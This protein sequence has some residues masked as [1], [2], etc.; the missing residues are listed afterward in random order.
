MTAPADKTTRTGPLTRARASMA[1]LETLDRLRETGQQ[2]TEADREVLRGW[3]GWGPMAPAF[4]P[5]RTGGWVEI[6][7]KIA[8]LL[9][10]EEQI[11]ARKA[12][13][14]AFYTPPEITQACWQILRDLGFEGG[15]ILEPG[16]GAGVF[17][18]HTPED[19]AGQV[20][21]LGIER[22]PSTAAIA[23]AIYPDAE[24]VTS[25]LEKARLPRASVDA[26]LGNVPF[27]D[28]LIFDPNAPEAVTR[29]LHN[30]AIWRS[31]QTLRPGGVAVLI[32]SR[33]TLDSQDRAAREA[34]YANCDL[35]SAIRLPNVA[36]RSGGTEPVA[37]IL[38]LRRRRAGEEPGDPT[39]LDAEMVPELGT[40]VNNLF[41]TRPDLVIGESKR[42]RAA[43]YG[44]VMRV[45]MP[46]G[47]DWHP[48]LTAVAERVSREALGRGLSW[49]VD[50][51]PEPIS[52]EN[53][54]LADAEGRK[55]GSFHLVDGKAV[56]VFEGTLRPVT[57]R[58][59]IKGTEDQYE[60][61]PLKGK[62][63]AELTALIGLRDTTVAVLDAEERA[64]AQE[65]IIRD[66]DDVT[67]D[68]RR[69]LAR[70]EAVLRSTMKARP[71]DDLQSLVFAAQHRTW[72]AGQSEHDTAAA[73]AQAW[74]RVERDLAATERE[75]QRAGTALA[76]ITTELGGLRGE[77]NRR[78]DAYQRAYGYLNRATISEGK[79]DE[80]TGLATIRR[81]PPRMGGFR[82]DPDYITVLALE[83]WDDDTRVGTKAAIFDR[84]VNTA[85]QRRERA[86]NVGEAIAL[87]L[88][89]HGKLH[90]PTIARLLDIEVTAV[91]EALGNLA[92]VDP[93]TGA[94]VTAE[95]YLSGN[96][97]VKLDQALAAAE[98]QPELWTRNVDALQDVQPADLGPGEIHAPLGAPWIPSDDVQA[99]L[100]ELLDTRRAM[101]VRRE[102]LT[103]TWEVKVDPRDK[104]TTAATAE[105]GTERVHAAKLV[106]LAL[107]GQ[108]PEVIDVEKLPD[109]TKQKTKNIEAT[110]AAEEKQRQIAAR[111]VE[112]I[113]EDPE[114]SDR[115]AERYN[116]LF[117]ATV[118]RRY[119]GSHLTFP[120]LAE[121][122]DPYPHQRDMV[123]RAIATETALCGHA[124]GGGKTTIMF[125]TAMKLRQLGLVQKPMIV[126]PK[127]L[128]EQTAREGKQ[129]F[130]N[131][132]ILVAD[133]NDM[134]DARSRKLFAAR[135]ATGDWDAVI[136]THPAFTRVPMHERNEAEYLAELAAKYR[137]SL[138]AV[139]AG[140]N[141]DE[142]DVAKV[143]LRTKQVEKLIDSL[144]SR[145]EYLLEHAHDDG[146]RFEHL[147][148]DHLL[149]DEFHY[150]KNLLV[151][152][153][154]EGFSMKHSKRATDM[155][156]KLTWLRSRYDRVATFYTGTAVSNSLLE[157]YIVLHYLMPERLEEM[158]IDSPDAWA[159]WCVQFETNV[160]IGPDGVTPRLNRRPSTFKNVRE[161]LMILAERSDIRS[162]EDL[163]LKVP[164]VEH[165]NVVSKASPLQRAYIQGLARRADAL[166][167]VRPEK[168]GDNMLAV[169]NDGRKVAVDPALVGLDDPGRGKIDDAI[170]NI[171]AT[172][173]QTVDLQFPA[174]D[175]HADDRETGVR[176][177]FQIV[178]CDL[179][180]PNK[181]RG[182][183]VYGKIRDGLVAQGVPRERIR[184]IH[185]AT[186]DAAKAKLFSE[187]RSGK[188][189]V[190]LGSTDKLG[191]GTNI[192]DRAVELHH[193]D[194]PWK[195]ADVEQ[196]EGRGRRPGN[197]MLALQRER[198]RR[199]AAGEPVP[200]NWPDKLKIKRYVT[201]GSFDGFMWQT[202]ER[203]A[204]FIAQV[205]SGKLTAGVREIDDVGEVT[206]SFAEVKALA[207]GNPLLMDM[208]KV[209]AEVSRL[210]SLS[211]SHTR[212]Q[213]RLENNIARDQR[214]IQ[215]NEAL[216]S[217]LEAIHTTADQAVRTARE[218][219]QALDGADVDGAVTTPWRTRDGRVLAED[220]DVDES[221]AALATQAVRTKQ[222]SGTW[223]TWRGLNIG[224]EVRDQGWRQQVLS[225]VI[226][227]RGKQHRVEVNAK[228]LAKGQ[229]YRFRQAVTGVVESAAARAED[230]R[231]SNDEA[232]SRI[233][234]ARAQL[235]RPFERAAEL[236][237]ARQR[238]D[239][240]NTEL[241]KA[242]EPR[243]AEVAE[244]PVAA[245][246]ADAGDDVDA[247]LAEVLGDEEIDPELSAMVL[248]DARAMA[249]LLGDDVEVLVNAQHL[250]QQRDGEPRVGLT[251]DRV[252]Y[253]DDPV[254]AEEELA[255]LR[256]RLIDLPDDY[257]ERA[258][259]HDA[260][261]RA[262]VLH[263]IAVTVDENPDRSIHRL[264]VSSQ[265]TSDQTASEVFGDLAREALEGRTGA[266][267]WRG[268][269][270]DFGMQDGRLT[271]ALSVAGDP[272]YPQ[273]GTF[274]DVPLEHDWADPDKPWRITRALDRFVDTAGQRARVARRQAVD[275]IEQHHAAAVVSE[276][277][278]DLGLDDLPDQQ[279]TSFVT[280]S[281][282]TS[283]TAPEAAEH[284]VN[285]LTDA[286]LEASDLTDRLLRMAEENP[287]DQ[288]LSD[289]GMAMLREAGVHLGVA[290]AADQAPGLDATRSGPP[291]SQVPADR[292]DRVL[293]EVARQALLDPRQA[294]HVLWRGLRLEFGVLAG[295]LVAAVSRAGDE[296]YRSPVYSEGANFL[297]VPLERQWTTTPSDHGRIRAA[298][299]DVVR[300]AP[301]RARTG[302]EQVA[303]LLAEHGG[304]RPAAAAGSPAPAEQEW[305]GQDLMALLGL[306]PQQAHWLKR[307]FVALAQHIEIRDAQ[308]TA[309]EAMPRFF[310]GALDLA[311]ARPNRAERSPGGA[312][313]DPA[314]L[315]VARRYAQD[316]PFADRLREVGLEQVRAMLDRDLAA[317]LPALVDALFTDLAL[318]HTDQDA[319]WIREWITAAAADP[320][321][322]QWARV[323][324]EDN[325]AQVLD[326]YL[327]EAV[328]VAMDGD[329]KPSQAVT[330]Y[331]LGTDEFLGQ[332]WR[333]LARAVVYDIAH[334][335]GVHTTAEP[336]H[337]AAPELAA[338]EVGA[339]LDPAPSAAAAEGTTRTFN[340]AA[341]DEYV[342]SQVGFDFRGAPRDLED[343]EPDANSDVTEQQSS[344]DRPVREERAAQVGY[345]GRALQLVA[346]PM[347]EQPVATAPWSTREAVARHLRSVGVPE[348]TV[349]ALEQS[350]NV[351]SSPSGALWAFRARSRSGGLPG[352]RW[353]VV[354]V[355]SGAQVR[356][357]LAA[358]TSNGTGSGRTDEV[359]P[360]ELDHAGYTAGYDLPD[361]AMPG[362]L[363]TLEHLLD[364]TGRQIDWTRP[365]EEVRQA[366]RQWRDLDPTGAL[367]EAGTTARTAGG[368]GL[369]AAA[370][371]HLAAGDPE[372]IPVTWDFHVAL[373]DLGPGT[374][375][376][377][378]GRWAEPAWTALEE[379][380]QDLDDETWRNADPARMEELRALDH[381]TL[382]V[383]RRAA[384]MTLGGQPQEA[385]ALLNERADQI[386]S[387][388]GSYHYGGRSGPLR[389]VAEQIAEL[390]S[391]EPTELQRLAQAQVGDVLAWVGGMET[392]G[393]DVTAWRVSEAARQITRRGE[394][395]IVVTADRIGGRDEQVVLHIP[396]ERSDVKDR[397][398]ELYYPDRAS[399]RDRR[400][401]ATRYLTWSAV[402]RWAMFDA[403]APVPTT[404]EEVKRQSLR[405]GRAFLA[406]FEPAAVDSPATKII[407]APNHWELAVAA[408]DR[409]PV[410]PLLPGPVE[411]VDLLDGYQ[412]DQHQSE[413]WRALITYAADAGYR[414]GW[415][416]PATMAHLGDA[417]GRALSVWS[418]TRGLLVVVD[419]RPDRALMDLAR[420]VLA[421]REG[422]RLN[423]VPL[424][425]ARSLLDELA[426]ESQQAVDPQAPVATAGDVPTH[427]PDESLLPGDELVNLR[428]GRA[429]EAHEAENWR[430][431]VD[432]A[433]DLGYVVV[434]HADDTV[435]PVDVQQ[436]RLLV[437]RDRW[438]EQ[439]LVDLAR[440][441]RAVREDKSV[442]DVSFQDA[443]DLL[444]GLA[445]SRRP[446]PQSAGGEAAGDNAPQAEAVELPTLRGLRAVAAAHELQV[447]VVRVAE[448]VFVT[449][450]E[451]SAP[452]PPVLSWPVGQALA[453]DGAGR[454]VPV[455]AISDH[456]SDYRVTIPAELLT[457]ETQVRDW[458]RRLAQLT[459]HMLTGEHHRS[460]VLDNVNAATRLAGQR[461]R[462]DEA[463]QWLRRA[464]DAAGP[465]R[466]TPERELQVVRAIHDLA[467]G[468]AWA[469]DVGR[470]LTEGH[471]HG[472]WQEWTWINEY[473]REHPEVLQGQPDHDAI[474]RR[475]E[476]E[477]KQA[478]ENAE[479]LVEQARAAFKA[480]DYEATFDLLDQAELA[481]PV[482]GSRL[483]AMRERV[484]ER[485]AK[486]QEFT[487][488]SAAP[489]AQVPAQREA[490]DASPTPATAE[491]GR[492]TAAGP[493]PDPTLVAPDYQLDLHAR[494][495]A[496]AA[497]WFEQQ[498]DASQ[499]AQ[500]YLQSRVAL[501][502]RID[503]AR[504][505]VGLSIGYAPAGW[506][507]LVD[508][509]RSR[510]F[511][512]QDMV[513]AG[514][515]AL[516]ERTGN[517]YDRFRNRIMFG[518]RDMQGRM[519]GFS[520]R[521]MPSNDDGPKYLN[522]PA[523]P[524]FDKSSLLFG[525]YEQRGRAEDPGVAPLF[526][527][528][529]MDVL[530]LVAA[531]QFLTAA[532]CGTALTS[533]QLAA[534]DALVPADRRRVLAL[535]G[536]GA[537]RKAGLKVA[538]DAA[539][540][541]TDLDV[542]TLPGGQDPAEWA[543]AVPFEEMTAAYQG[544]PYSRPVLEVLADARVDSW[545]ERLQWIEGRV[546]AA[547]HVARLL[548]PYEP[549]RIA[550][551]AL[552]IAT[553]LEIDPVYM[554][555]YIAEA[556]QELG[557]PAPQP[558]PRPRPAA[559]DEPAPQVA[560]TSAKAADEP[561]AEPVPAVTAEPSAPPDLPDPTT[562]AAAN[563]P[564][565]AT[566]VVPA[567]GTSPREQQAGP[568][569][570][571]QRTPPA[572]Q[573]PSATGN[574]T[575]E[576]DEPEP[577][578]WSGRITV[579]V[580][581]STAVV[582]GTDRSRDPQI[583]RDTLKD[584]SFKWRPKE[585]A[586]WKFV[587][588]YR[589]R[590]R[591]AAVRAV[592]DVL[593][594]LDAKEAAKAPPAAPSYPP[595]PQQQKIID[596]FAEG[597]DVAV[598]ALAGTGKTS[599]LRMIAALAPDRKI[600]YIAFNRSIADEA[601]EAFGRN[602][603]ADT[604]HAFARQALRN[605]PRYQAKLGQVAKN[606]GFPQEIAPL[607]GLDANTTVRYGQRGEQE[608]D[609]LTL[610]RQA[611]A[612]VKRFRESADKQISGRHLSE[613]VAQD[614]HG[615]G[616]L[617]LDY[618]RRIWADK[619][620][621][622]GELKFAHDDYL[623]IWALGDPTIPGD[624]IFFDEVQDVNELQARL[625]QAQSAQTV[626]VGDTYQSI[627]GFRGAK[628]FL[629]NWPADVTLPLTQSWRF[630]PLVAD[631]G[632][633]F[634]RL[635][636]SKLVLEGNPALDTRLDR[637]DD[638]DAVLCRTNAGAVAA[639][640]A[641][642]EDGKRVALVGGG[643]DIKDIARAAKDLQRGKRTK[644]PELS[645][646]GSWWDVREYVNAH[647][648]AQSLK[649]FVRL[650]D[651][652]GPDGLIAMAD[653]LVDER[654]ADPEL[655][656]Q[657]VVSTAH[658]A[659][660]REWD[661][662][663]IAD[664]FKGPTEDE[665]TGET[666]LPPP[667]ELRLAYVTVT[668][669][670]KRLELGSLEWV[671]AYGDPSAAPDAAESERQQVETPTVIAVPSAPAPSAE[672][673]L[674]TAQTAIPHDDRRS[675]D[676]QPGTPAT[677]TVPDEPL[678]DVIP[679][680]A[681]DLD[682]GQWGWDMRAR[683][684]GRDKRVSQ[685]WSRGEVTLWVVRNA[686]GEWDREL[687]LSLPVTGTSPQD[688]APTA[689]MVNVEFI[690]VDTRQGLLEVLAE[691]GRH[692]WAEQSAAG[693]WRVTT[694]PTATAA[695]GAVTSRAE[696]SH[697]VVRRSGDDIWVFAAT[698]EPVFSTPQPDAD[699]QL[700]PTEAL[701][702]ASDAAVTSTAPTVEATTPSGPAVDGEEARRAAEGSD[703]NA[704]GAAVHWQ[705]SQDEALAA[706]GLDALEVAREVET[707][708]GKFPNWVEN[709]D[710]QR[711]LR[712]NLYK[713]VIE[714]PGEPRKAV[715][716]QIMQVIAAP[717]AQEQVVGTGTADEVTEEGSDAYDPADYGLVVVPGADRTLDPTRW[718]WQRVD[719]QQNEGGVVEEWRRGDWSA[720]I[721]WTFDD[722]LATPLYLQTTNMVFDEDSRPVPG[723]TRW[724]EM[725]LTI[726]TAAE[727]REVM[728]EAGQHGWVQP[729]HQ[730]GLWWLTSTPTA[731]MA[732]AGTRADP[733]RREVFLRVE[734]GAWLFADTGEEV[735][736]APPSPVVR[737]ADFQ[738]V[739]RFVLGR[740]HRD[741]EARSLVGAVLTGRTRAGVPP[742]E[743]LRRVADL[744]Q[745]VY[746]RAVVA[747]MGGGSGRG[748]RFDVQKAQEALQRLVD[749]DPTL[750]IPA[751]DRAPRPAEDA[752][753]T[754]EL[755]IDSDQQTTPDSPGPAMVDPPPDGAQPAHEP[756]TSRFP[757]EL[758]AQDVL[759]PEELQ[760]RIRERMQ[761]L[762]RE[763]EGV[764]T[765][766]V[767]LALAVAA[768]MLTSGGAFSA[769]LT[770]RRIAGNH[771]APLL[772]ADRV[773]QFADLIDALGVDA[774]ALREALGAY[775]QGST[776]VEHLRTV[777]ERITVI[778]RD[779]MQLARARAAEL[780]ASVNANTLRATRAAVANG[781]SAPAREFLGNNLAPHLHGLV[782]DAA[783][784]VLQDAFVAQAALTLFDPAERAQ[785]ELR[786]EPRQEQRLATAIALRALAAEGRAR[787]RASDAA[788][789]ALREA[790]FDAITYR[791]DE[792]AG[793]MALAGDFTIPDEDDLAVTAQKD[794]PRTTAEKAAPLTD[795]DIAVALGR[796]APWQFAQ[797]VRDLENDEVRAPSTSQ[798]ISTTRGPGEPDVGADERLTLTGPALRIEVDAA[799]G[800]RAGRLPWKRVQNWLR[801]GL[802]P[803]T[804]RVLLDAD[805]AHNRFRASEKGFVAIGERDQAAQVMRELDG[806]RRQAMTDLLRDALTAHETGARRP[807]RRRGGGQ[808]DVLISAFPEDVTVVL[809]RI[810]VL[811]TVLPA[812][813]DQRK[814]VS[815]I[816]VGDVVEHP[817]YSFGPFRI[818]RA[819]KV[820]DDR[821]ELVGE[822]LDYRPSG[823]GPVTWQVSTEP[824]GGP[825][826][827]IVAQPRSLANVLTAPQAVV[828][829]PDRSGGTVDQFPEHVE[830]RDDLDPR[831]FGW[832]R[833]ELHHDDNGP[834]EHWQRNESSLV[835][836]WT[837]SDD[838]LLLANPLRLHG[839]D[840]PVGSVEELRAVL[841][842]AGLHGYARLNGDRWAVTATPT[843]SYAAA[844]AASDTALRQVHLDPERGW[845]FTDTGDPVPT[846]PVS[847]QTTSRHR[848]SPQRAAEEQADLFDLL[849]P[850]SADARVAGSA[851][852][853]S[854]PRS[855]T[856]VPEVAAEPSAAPEEV[857]HPEPAGPGDEATAGPVEWSTPPDPGI[858]WAEME[859]FASQH[860]FTV[861]KRQSAQGVNTDFELM[862]I[863]VP[864]DSEGVDSR[865][866]LFEELVRLSTS[867]P[868]VEPERELEPASEPTPAPTPEPELAVEEVA[869][870]AS[871]VDDEPGL[872]LELGLP[873][874]D[875]DADA[876]DAD[877]DP[878]AA[879]AD[880]D[881][882]DLDLALTAPGSHAEVEEV[883]DGVDD[884]QV[885][886]V[887]ERSGPR[888]TEPA[889]VED[890][891]RG[892]RQD[893]AAADGAAAADS[894][895]AKSSEPPVAS[896]VAE[897]LQT[898]TSGAAPNEAGDVVTDEAPAAGDVVAS[899]SGAV[900]P[901]AE[902]DADRLRGPS[903]VMDD[904]I[905]Q[906]WSSLVAEAAA[907]GFMVKT[908]HTGQS[909]VDWED[910]TP[911]SA[912]TIFIS[913]DQPPLSRVVDLAKKVAE[914]GLHLSQVATVPVDDLPRQRTE[915]PEEAPRSRQ[916][917]LDVAS[918][919][920]DGDFESFN[921]YLAVMATIAAEDQQLQVRVVEEPVA[922]E[923][924]EP[925]PAPKSDT[926]IYETLLRELGVGDE[927]GTSPGPAP[928]A[929]PES[930][931]RAAEVTTEGT[932]RRAGTELPGVTPGRIGGRPTTASLGGMSARGAGDPLS[933]RSRNNR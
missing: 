691:A 459:P 212:T 383:V 103:S 919:V 401:I 805:A 535:D 298:I 363:H 860:G 738:A 400:D 290:W 55:E 11:E 163:G 635:L 770:A 924:V 360:L 500:R 302:R 683:E 923:P 178:F 201:E 601:Q 259:A 83:N 97:R 124:V 253:Q 908:R 169:C 579:Q 254:Q 397:S 819:P 441:V 536:D 613:A 514:V 354:H 390:F 769:D 790:G 874:A 711:Q 792:V 36:W 583:L 494:I 797:I 887:A 175:K 698:G 434:R 755:G 838:D 647:E 272:D 456:L 91:P 856:T 96:V 258:A 295:R 592:R 929:G 727:F 712:A 640:I 533:G 595:T 195:P 608:I 802:N 51:A 337:P 849:E 270:V 240:I 921:V 329:N 933:P 916:G 892:A 831:D 75:R 17:M 675:P 596:A 665:E 324:H 393:P 16:C 858:T 29:N 46:E 10:P 422:K 161:L 767:H 294:E 903:A 723:V 340:I 192:Q 357:V 235:G 518:I 49:N 524:L 174:D 672:P 99:F 842:E 855:S 659:K 600:T 669:A 906:Q 851:Q 70:H 428:D 34:L 700:A 330:D 220:K 731:A 282:S 816:E 35:V 721:P 473:A 409:D 413:R 516:S 188:V 742:D 284:G 221:L 445:R 688:P 146:V 37:D 219:Q 207:T 391:P 495:N 100:A 389:L 617:V 850:P 578:L 788:G 396:V 826:L 155:D 844:A 153:H 602:V 525:L 356:A 123:Y 664:D 697:L 447:S 764:P 269:R 28:T 556:R 512:D 562:A 521:L 907:L 197:R 620:S 93:A 523:T 450:H 128:L 548:A 120:G 486:A 710:E 537:G 565:P 932:A 597:K 312:Q 785:Q 627:Y 338:P 54:V 631:L 297:S 483:E 229:R 211:A 605:D 909:V 651:K 507:G 493:V 362:Y 917:A 332:R 772:V 141:S 278:R 2:P 695:R 693:Q 79:P 658:K 63:L 140:E 115:L 429:V 827:R 262:Y 864:W 901:P 350:R 349:S 279:T 528:G 58:R 417:R 765:G 737:L 306:D 477:R 430:A 95:E 654:E 588:S 3:A 471:L 557:L 108:T 835:L 931:R 796:L 379:L 762:P 215:E 618:A 127:H 503:H 475:D 241:R 811:T 442:N 296:D 27:A 26:V 135:C 392:G 52:A 806:Y 325:F 133:E 550:G 549:E 145:A 789:R 414:V 18:G 301:E 880:L 746:R 119:D 632:N 702:A 144:E 394:N 530:A 496:E 247:L 895:P 839:M 347:A 622:T 889:Q 318:P 82:R 446:D 666:L 505:V 604:M 527:E 6:G 147:G 104:K 670:K 367:P 786:Q 771:R 571:D 552:R 435:N 920:E 223:L 580:T 719:H 15:R 779:P 616:N 89:E 667:E 830:V 184:F 526:V 341:G 307:Q 884:D 720:A 807:R 607:L 609:A 315:E 886:P 863:T 268:L 406:Q 407:Q 316:R 73:S 777:A 85:P 706:A 80:E 467:S 177:G 872:E 425:D 244:E 485:I 910:A 713:L 741:Q 775:D 48:G 701:Q 852:D 249:E 534:V 869:E 44:R 23:Q 619:T 783:R 740:H 160:E 452:V 878:W 497:R 570:L 30:Y 101:T 87:C 66:A 546:D 897:G 326:D 782:D 912:G 343:Q 501:P 590:N 114:R 799:S 716:E 610:V 152:C 865:A 433:A 345:G 185:D 745:E 386:A 395:Q 589:Q 164:E 43:Q 277:A 257:P 159:A 911:Q 545:G 561:D 787:A 793:R 439:A 506:T 890:V 773:R 344:A 686:A 480:R 53:T 680:L 308:R 415:H 373:N 623:K 464:E 784:R 94:W 726:S 824:E 809:D 243:P 891:A 236:H 50:A 715:V 662:V 74:E 310:R 638:P 673:V 572:Q 612:A 218:E 781:T 239:V 444:A 76:E 866:L 656:P 582:S 502:E 320:K 625:V 305:A 879:L 186:S 170:D 71:D 437:A 492:V 203:K 222:H 209:K 224:F 313:L 611:L 293:A 402:D 214:A 286:M 574:D 187:C 585:G 171:A 674:G 543:L 734:D 652:H 118:L 470:Y 148:V 418:E 639:V 660:G 461:D 584:N 47:A 540:H 629:T 416:D 714:L 757:M 158:G 615:L 812:E 210:S 225:A 292:L 304:A 599:T 378:D 808:G 566:Q 365:I 763:I 488:E 754:L 156:M 199:L 109:G 137:A 113:W 538:E 853:E 730:P 451:P 846:G 142:E 7:D 351:L 630:G 899:P 256:A 149:V 817:G 455:E 479:Q 364:A 776:F 408:P 208:A 4:E 263:Q 888:T 791:V 568:D 453:F 131:A 915:A 449:V 458:P 676:A 319:R 382:G 837:S 245:A 421:A 476:A 649:A 845:I 238:L 41:T 9:T 798:T 489:Q 358:E 336:P 289:Q 355:P 31:V 894:E 84:R 384:A 172:Y 62:E 735:P 173:H 885:G 780:F 840:H 587:P 725:E 794:E 276:A 69:E 836:T 466:L 423:D 431:L 717:A 42:D 914:V 668:R 645:A 255:D 859:Q 232:R 847:P 267:R 704:V 636:R 371:M 40:E 265:A 642:M 593:R 81:I 198:E 877:P 555:E 321:V 98:T 275:L 132:K 564:V 353:F 13:P 841:A 682:P 77:L 751:V 183:Q 5:D 922:E 560:P 176:G 205:M 90:L 333:G 130:P 699:N 323:N 381:V 739:E 234:A 217:A 106:E 504:Q 696:R 346:R 541:Y 689:G 167:G 679:D 558:R 202:L 520:G 603:R 559:L 648:D 57:T 531:P 139:L 928:M 896:G 191:V 760:S 228:W 190:L 542:T 657:L 250:P 544:A 182:D 744:D 511:R 388:D 125:M 271:A 403:D 491:D 462:A 196:R 554:A 317:D 116:R 436:R 774:D 690:R 724:E 465:L 334:R 260:F 873:D 117:N 876:D 168:G 92:Y 641:A 576:P 24:I 454:P 594:E 64:V 498:Y 801:A 628:D 761:D 510:G 150:F 661:R 72:E 778:T 898:T 743:A 361:Q 519:A 522:T 180:T 266:A 637:L 366:L 577:G 25:K 331:L 274:V 756:L 626:V 529:P 810:A 237:E 728:A 553:R 165:V 252:V 322:L 902:L 681:E 359:D 749:G 862:T 707:M 484:R 653:D 126:V 181:E 404:V 650:V 419:H 927:H 581:G 291:P 481:N 463:D 261:A 823:E 818:T 905:A 399:S 687:A 820:H 482:A 420:G 513:D 694:T 460:A 753:A 684:E 335:R 766:P 14:N 685:E 930:G 469:G 432:Q 875:A 138:T 166:K 646:F 78:Y 768:S 213:R 926:P 348:T 848:R 532:P 868:V 372:R 427:R 854:L 678:S 227:T 509:L 893:E 368:I 45:D 39:W 709:P 162:Q 369:R 377:I 299:E 206:L 20:S 352:D 67:R 438:P 328:V 804:S 230:L 870:A 426:P 517:I 111:F 800:Q 448:N 65:R 143:G 287:A 309:P 913:A 883:A 729:S 508:H 871:G 614:Q 925:A 61:V 705:L 591:D 567:D 598:R 398:V 424:S 829:G 246:D 834:V 822:L 474:R 151:P 233:E 443:H 88:D 490:V 242:T 634:L 515:A 814:H 8:W 385:V 314:A 281:G 38:V 200:A 327:V 857:S 56:E 752:P 60:D 624:V 499:A 832:V 283:P 586:V 33:Y 547:R 472:S 643:G 795:A 21:W 303:A 189:S 288:A 748:R 692:G 405:A 226:N 663:R 370:V 204:R 300:A 86:D 376:R 342:A 750:T 248:Q 12:T 821:V 122:F 59:K 107:N 732:V 573:E 440:A 154:T 129:R 194:A 881:P 412:V 747:A 102:P 708:L 644:H 759:D 563:A 457:V 136:I 825:D 606:D 551:V 867:T 677:D 311:L 487:A 478:E 722:D 375:E 803:A 251:P 105:W 411:L 179:G 410:L 280:A 736:L 285:A 733:Q 273:P 216:A 671:L 193:I 882:A 121:G 374:W 861:V 843:T 900:Q 157:L 387:E 110:T 575:S 19:L 655:K 22:D 621:P 380:A 264:G 904:P 468:Y 718:G 231:H 539:R 758:A 828:R 569:H 918:A 1:A 339:P 68:L 32:T 815:L 813:T 112:W 134:S 833:Q 633:N 703:L